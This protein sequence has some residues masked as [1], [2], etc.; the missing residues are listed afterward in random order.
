MKAEQVLSSALLDILFEN[1]NK[2]Y[3]AYNLRKFYNNRLVKALAGMV[4]LAALMFLFIRMSVK[5]NIK[6]APVVPDVETTRVFELP[7][8][9]PVEPPKPKAPKTAPPVKTASYA[10]VEKINIT[11][12]EANVAPLVKNLNDVAIATITQDGLQKSVQVIQAPVALGTVSKDVGLLAATI[13]DPSIPRNTADI[14]PAY[15]GGMEALRKFLQKNL[16]NPEE[17]VPGEEVLVK[18]KFIVGY[19]GKLHGFNIEKDGG[20]AFNQEVIRVLRKMPEWIPGKSNGQNV[21][22]YYTIPVRFM[23]TE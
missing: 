19:D 20:R 23:V 3:G 14:M 4:L 22:V 15:P 12:D 6:A 17:V 18:I 1:R 5:G 8:A 7:P 2:G 9:A 10:Y 13:P 11:K 16:N 21:A